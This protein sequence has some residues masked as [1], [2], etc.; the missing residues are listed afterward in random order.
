MRIAEAGEFC[1]ISKEIYARIKVLLK[2]QYQTVLLIALS[3][4]IL[5]ITSYL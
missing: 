3:K 2:A 1:P 4:I 5:Q